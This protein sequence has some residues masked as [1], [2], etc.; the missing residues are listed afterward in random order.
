MRLLHRLEGMTLRYE[1]KPGSNLLG[2][3]A[4][5][6]V[7][8]EDPAVSVNHCEVLVEDGRVLVRDLNSTNGTFVNGKPV[9]N[10]ELRIGDRLALGGLEVELEPPPV[11][12]IPP[13]QE[14]VETPV[15]LPDGRPCC[16]KHS[17]LAAV[18][19]CSACQGT[20]CIECVHHIR[21][22]GGKSLHLCPTCGGHCEALPEFA[23]AVKARK[24][25]FLDVLRST[26]RL[27]RSK[28]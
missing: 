22:V 21:R 15:L 11:I 28:H 14:V 12:N 26:I 10:A 5:C 16:L 20:F 8:L 7:Q 23:R 6:D 2:R 9:E 4:D 3:G 27:T 24:R 18:A 1:L 13:P 25:N 17:N 19:Q